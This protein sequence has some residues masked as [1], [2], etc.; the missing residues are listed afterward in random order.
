MVDG[1]NGK[2]VGDID[3]GRG[4]DEDN[5]GDYEEGDEGVGVRIE[6]APGKVGEIIE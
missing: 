3:E 2:G 1:E 4:F 5:E 6:V